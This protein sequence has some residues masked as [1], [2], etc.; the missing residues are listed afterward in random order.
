MRRPE[1]RQPPPPPR[2]Q[3][4]PQQLQIFRHT[5]SFVIPNANTRAHAHMLYGQLNS[6]SL[7]HSE[8][9]WTH[10][11]AADT[12]VRTLSMS[13][14]M[15]NNRENPLLVDR[16]KAAAEAR[17]EPAPERI[18]HRSVLSRTRSTATPPPPNR[19]PALGQGDSFGPTGAGAFACVASVGRARSRGGPA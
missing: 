1:Q 15:S 6:I 18:E 16:R 12:C 13:M 14:S 4:P 19:R 5:E 8:L 9:R 3:K 2:P 7:T 10:N 11:V 17:G